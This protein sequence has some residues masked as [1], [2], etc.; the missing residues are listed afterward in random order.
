MKI[1]TVWQPW[2][3][4]IAIGLKPYEFRGWMPPASIIGQRIGV[5]AAARKV[6]PGEVS[7]LITR[8]RTD[9]ASVCLTDG[10]LP[11]LE[12]VARHPER[13]PLS[14]IVCTAVLGKPVN[15]LELAR[16]F[17]A[18]VNDSD[19]DEHAN[20]GWPMLAVQPLFPPIEAAGRQG[21]WDFEVAT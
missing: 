9:P 10:V 4:L 5:H 15:G 7:D 3:S 12:E 16:Q 8:V 18:P 14:A 6:K 19:R 11:W 13:L 2:A 1:I 21:F 17:G 20:F